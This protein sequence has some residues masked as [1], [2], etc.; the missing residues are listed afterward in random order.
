[1]SYARYHIAGII[2]GEKTSPV[3]KCKLKFVNIESVKLK[4][5]GTKPP[6]AIVAM[7]MRHCLLSVKELKEV[8][9]KVQQS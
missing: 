7:L 4:K 1:M 5:Y 8:N 9:K 2:G 6:H 3:W